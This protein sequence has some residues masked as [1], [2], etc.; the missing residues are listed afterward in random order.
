MGWLT[1]ITGFFRR[2][3]GVAEPDM[4]RLKEIE[5][6]LR[7]QYR[8]RL[9]AGVPM[10]AEEWAM[11]DEDEAGVFMQ[12]LW[13]DE[14]DK[15]DRTRLAYEAQFVASALRG[16]VLNVE[17]AYERL[18]PETQDAQQRERAKVAAAIR[19]AHRNIA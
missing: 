10:T 12:N 8:R 7:E 9:E 19:K 14:K 11:M 16:N 6:G 18:D 3:S 15:Y 2:R 5:D 17:A 4:D 1:R 13:L